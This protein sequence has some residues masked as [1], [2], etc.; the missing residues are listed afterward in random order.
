M[1]RPFFSPDGH[2]DLDL[3]RRAVEAVATEL[4][5]PPISA[6]QMYQSAR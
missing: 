1:G 3:A 6:D 5:V 4:G 2:V